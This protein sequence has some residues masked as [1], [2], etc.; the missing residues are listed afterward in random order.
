MRRRDIIFACVAWGCFLAGLF[1]A[2][3]TQSR[4]VQVYA[5]PV[6]VIHPQMEDPERSTSVQPSITG[7]IG[8]FSDDTRAAMAKGLRPTPD[9]PRAVRRSPAKADSRSAPPVNQQ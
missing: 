3:S 4:W 9:A 1:W 8:T 2:L 7:V 5:K 6:R